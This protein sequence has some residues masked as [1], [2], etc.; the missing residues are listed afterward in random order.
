MNIFSIKSQK[1]SFSGDEES[2]KYN[3]AKKEKIKNYLIYA[4]YLIP[5][6][7]SI[8]NGHLKFTLILRIILLK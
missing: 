3:S 8:L 2:K 5:T 7:F 1:D 6:F 4:H